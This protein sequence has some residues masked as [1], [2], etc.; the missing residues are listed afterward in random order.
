[1]ARRVKLDPRFIFDRPDEDQ[2]V[3]REDP[4]LCS[5]A[6]V[7]EDPNLRGHAVVREDPIPCV[8]V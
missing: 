6:V 5:Q 8:S 7:R 4:N 1:M 3:V 2:A